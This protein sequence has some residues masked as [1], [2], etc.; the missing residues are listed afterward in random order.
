MV[1]YFLLLPQSCLW[2]P[3]L[4]SSP[5]TANSA[6]ISTAGPLFSPCH[7]N[8]IVPSANSAPVLTARPFS[9]PPSLPL[10]R[11]TLTV[12]TVE[13]IFVVP[14]PSWGNVGKFYSWTTSEGWAWNIGPYKSYD[15]AEVSPTWHRVTKKSSICQIVGSVNFI[16]LVL[17][18]AF[19]L[20]WALYIVLEP[21]SVKIATNY[22]F[23][24]T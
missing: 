18:Q 14:L 5:L 7:P 11:G 6:L 22:S 4:L 9:L 24:A 13:R 8:T 1:G 10:D 23:L 2:L 20:S 17:N 16:S 15:H 3:K 19:T 21:P 12:P